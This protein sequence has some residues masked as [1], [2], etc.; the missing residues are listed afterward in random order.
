MGKEAAGVDSAGQCAKCDGGEDLKVEKQRFSAVS[1][2]GHKL[3]WYWL[4]GQSVNT[5]TH[6]K[7]GLW[8]EGRNRNSDFNLSFI[9]YSH[10]I[11]CSLQ[12]QH[13]AVS[14][15]ALD[16]LQLSQERRNKDMK[17]PQK[18]SSLVHSEKEPECLGLMG[19]NFLKIGTL[20]SK[21]GA[22]GREDGLAR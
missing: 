6:M 4:R 10:I 1:Y 19:I 15:F 21:K 11:D 20:K 13:C 2:L 8:G 5:H 7:T 18:P 22:R 12:I 17:S 3:P 9:H 14:G 16:N